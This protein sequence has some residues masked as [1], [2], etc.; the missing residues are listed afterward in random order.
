LPTEQLRRPPRC[1]ERTDRSV[2]CQPA[3]RPVRTERVLFVCQAVLRP[4]VV[5]DWDASR[6]DRG[7]VVVA[8]LR[9]REWLGRRAGASGCE[10]AALATE[11]FPGCPPGPAFASSAAARRV[12]A[13]CPSRPTAWPG[14]TALVGHPRRLRRRRRAV[15][16]TAHPSR[17]RTRSPTAGARRA[18]RSRVN[19]SRGRSAVP[20]GSWARPAR[21]P[22]PSRRCCARI[23][24]RCCW[25]VRA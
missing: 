19:S 23:C 7:V 1:H 16:P 4:A 8:F 3:H 2:S 11:S 6:R 24:R 22:T 9:V 14:R 15:G 10:P 21:W 20:G 17:S 18:G 12:S 13:T 5:V 25:W